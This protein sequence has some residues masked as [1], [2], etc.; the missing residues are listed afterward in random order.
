MEKLVFHP[1]PILEEQMPAFDFDNPIMDPKE[2]E[3]ELLAIM[4]ANNGIGLA[5]PQ[6]GIRT[7]VFAMGHSLMPEASLAMFNPTVIDASNEF[8]DIEE[9]CLS[10]PSIFAKIKRPTWI[11]VKYNTSENEERTERMEGY[12]CKCFLHELDHLDGI[13]MKDRLSQLKWALAVK[14]SKKVKNYVRTK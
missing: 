1:D 14:K 11:V 4:F 10:F 13:V 5:S 8:Q 2:L 6:I 7:R 3:K 9:G 12:N